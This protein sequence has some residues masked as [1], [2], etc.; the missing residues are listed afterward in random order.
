VFERPAH[1]TV[2]TILA[3]L[4]ASRLS[5]TRFLFSGG[6][7]I[8]LEFEEFRESRDVDFLCSYGEGYGELRQLMRSEGYRGVFSEAGLTRLEFSREPQIDQYGIRFPVL[9]GDV[10][11]KVELIREARISLGPPARPSW[12]PVDCLSIADCFAEKLL[13]NSDRWADRQVLSRDLVDLGALCFFEGP[14]P[15]AA[16]Q[17]AERA[18]RSAVRSDLAKALAAFRGD[19]AWQQRCWEGLA[20]TR[21]R[22]ILD[23][24]D[25]LHR[26]LAEGTAGV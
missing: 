5:T 17:K 10:M 8:A 12:S 18:Y 2:A 6:T 22:D 26:Q 25:R 19:K 14:V 9:S 1:R 15:E 3:S 7:R 23:G 24:C 21:P 11:A 20:V 4:D 13:A 16:W